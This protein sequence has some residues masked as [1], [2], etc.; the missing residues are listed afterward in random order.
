MVTAVG[1][2]AV[3]EVIDDNEKGRVRIN[4]LALF[5][6][7]ILSLY[8]SLCRRCLHNIDAPK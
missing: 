7:S 2:T 4:L 5:L 1:T 3:V 6:F 8:S